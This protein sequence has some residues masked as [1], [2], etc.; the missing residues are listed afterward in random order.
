MQL[1][2][3]QQQLP[4]D[5][6]FIIV[7]YCNLSTRFSLM[8]C[9]KS[10][11]E[12]VDNQGTW[13]QFIIDYYAFD[14]HNAVIVDYKNYL[15]KIYMF[16]DVTF[17]GLHCQYPDYKPYT[18]KVKFTKL[19]RIYSKTELPEY[20]NHVEDDE[21]VLKSSGKLLWDVFFFDLVPGILDSE[22]VD[23]ITG[24]DSLLI[25]DEQLV[26]KL[27]LYEHSI[28][29]SP[30]NIVV[31][32]LYRSFLINRCIMLG[33]SQNVS[34]T[35]YGS[36]NGDSFV[37]LMN[38]VVF[39]DSADLFMKTLQ[40]TSSHTM[41]YSGHICVEATDAGPHLNYIEITLNK[42][43]SSIN[44]STP[45]T[46]SDG[47]VINQVLAVLPNPIVKLR[48]VKEAVI[49]N[50][51]WTALVMD[52]SCRHSCRTDTASFP[53]RYE[54]RLMES[55]DM[56]IAHIRGEYLIGHFNENAFYCKLIQ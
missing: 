8:T 21:I 56:L 33:F 4:I 55:Q 39:N 16:D 5:V 41:L 22:Q 13:K 25:S 2:S 32:N 36:T 11:F 45:E 9:A 54:L 42:Q 3:T 20:Y 48:A 51:N 10:L 44:G 23:A 18:M 27:I 46:T 31:P 6:W 17:E 28:E 14:L 38:E 19:N 52:V 53:D 29:R 49:S 35:P 50:S 34:D 7:R 37:A 40:D 15:Y 43:Q 30:A 26:H 47:K 1:S 24:F 12:I